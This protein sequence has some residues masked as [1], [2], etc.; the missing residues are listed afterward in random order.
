VPISVRVPW[1]LAA[2]SAFALLLTL[3]AGCGRSQTLPEAEMTHREPS[4]RPTFDFETKRSAVMGLRGVVATSQP[5]AANAGLD[6]LKRGGNAV[7]AAIATAAVLTVVEPAA[8]SLGGDLFALVWL[9]REKKLVGLNAS[10]RAAAG[11][12]LEE[13][14]ARLREE[15]RRGIGGIYSVTVP[16]AVDGWC[17]LL[18][19]YGTMSLAEVLEPAIYYAEHGF[20]VTERIGGTFVSNR[21]KLAAEPSAAAT[22][23]INGRPPMVG[24][25]L[26]NR[27][28]ARS[29]RLL[30]RQGRKA[31]YEGEIARAIVAYGQE[32]GGFLTLED[33]RA[34]T[35]DWVEPIWAD[36]GD[37][38]LYELPPNGQGIAALEMLKILAHVD[39]ASLGHN[40]AEYLHY[41]IEA[42]KLAYADIDRWNA[43]PAFND[44]PV[45]RMISEDYARA[46]FERID[47]RRAAQRVR[48]G[49]EGPGDTV[50]LTV[51]DA[52]HNAV[53]LIYSIYSEF[54]SGLV[55]P[56]YGFTLQNRGSLF[57]LDP[58]HVNAYAP[59][60]RPFHTIIPAMAFKGEDLFMSFGVMG[61]SVQPQQQVQ[62][63]LNVVAFGM[64]IQ[65]AFE[66]PRINHDGG[67][68]VTTEPGIDERVLARL[69]ALGHV[70][71]RRTTI[72]GVGGG[73]GILFD[74]ATGVMMGGST[75]HKDGAAVAW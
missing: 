11:A 67:L 74:A 17:E 53:S 24:E 16:G 73:Q 39:V 18:E 46:Q 8:T 26:V 75:P 31:F 47:P 50:Y 49:I 52:E 64:N 70:L 40:S 32:K 15:E 22:W 5:L 14:Q 29:L 63:L 7:D 3:S 19:T 72:G 12:T 43:D 51:M 33:L 1:S 45:E 68:R 10:G 57:S 62:V 66:V 54:G 56:G 2:A 36:Y 60:K 20:P 4:I 37:Y 27:D 71:T 21:R 69:E 23:L 13:L 30:A 58:E 61:G 25:V 65:Q 55:V 42:K 41:L 34:H 59:R 35:S 28:L 48:S 44:L 6:I 38:R 9:A